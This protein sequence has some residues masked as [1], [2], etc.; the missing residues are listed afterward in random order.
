MLISAIHQS[1]P[2]AHTHTHTHI[3][4]HIFSITVYYRILSIVGFPGITVVKN[5]PANA[6][7]RMCGFD[8]RVEKI[9]WRREWLPT[10]VFLPG[11]SYGQRS[12]AGCS[13]WGHKE[14]ETTKKVTL[15]YHICPSGVSAVP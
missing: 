15:S 6:G 10:L 4:F 5:P 7:D 3:L 13:L 8:L 9:L 11:K 1:Y 14:S 12:L 2:I